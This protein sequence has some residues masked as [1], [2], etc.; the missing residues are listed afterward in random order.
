MDVK[1]ILALPCS[2]S[3]WFVNV[4]EARWHCLFAADGCGPVLEVPRYRRVVDHSD[5]VVAFGDRFESDREP[6]TF[7]RA[8]SLLFLLTWPTGPC[9]ALRITLL[10]LVRLL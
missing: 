9:S 4:E 2:C 5:P 1:S 10:S 3:D 6:F 8:G 7:A